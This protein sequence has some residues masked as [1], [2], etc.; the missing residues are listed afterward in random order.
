MTNS[1][2]K[3]HPE[4][5]PP[6]L[7]RLVGPAGTAPIPEAPLRVT[8]DVD[9]GHAAERYHF[10]YEANASGDVEVSLTDAFRDL[11]EERAKGTDAQADV[12]SILE[13]VDVEQLDFQARQVHRF[14]PGSLIGRLTISD[15]TNR[16]TH[17]FMADAEQAKTAGIEPDPQIREILEKIYEAGASQLGRKDIRP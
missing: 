16:V 5:G 8:L 1:V 14:P 7:A 13:M 3:Q 2:R 15:G 4:L 12:A 17:L 6:D 9:N 10:H 11:T